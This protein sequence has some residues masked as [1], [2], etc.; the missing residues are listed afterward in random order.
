MNFIRHSVH[1]ICQAVNQILRQS[2]KPFPTTCR[3]LLCLVEV[4][5]VEHTSAHLKAIIPFC[6]PHGSCYTVHTKA[7]WLSCARH[8]WAGEQ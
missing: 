7:L 2:A 5:Q 3:V 1:S 8:N 6:E 4:T